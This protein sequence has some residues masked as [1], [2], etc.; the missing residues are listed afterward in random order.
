MDNVDIE[1]IEANIKEIQESFVKAKNHDGS[2]DK[3]DELTRELGEILGTMVY[4][5]NGPNDFEVD[6]D[7]L[8]KLAAVGIIGGDRHN[9]T[10]FIENPL[11]EHEPIEVKIIDPTDQ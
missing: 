1:D 6:K 7:E 2:E 8:E 10:L 11:D 9:P 5:A 3:V 4:V